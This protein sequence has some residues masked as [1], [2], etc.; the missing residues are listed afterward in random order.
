[1][2]VTGQGNHLVGRYRGT[3]RAYRVAYREYDYVGFD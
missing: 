3:H 1:M 2:G